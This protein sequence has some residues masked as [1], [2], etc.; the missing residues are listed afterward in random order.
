MLEPLQLVGKANGDIP[1]SCQQGSMW[2]LS[3][4]MQMAEFT[5]CSN[6]LLLPS[7]LIDM[8]AVLLHADCWVYEQVRANVKSRHVH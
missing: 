7:I 2:L 3:C 8:I 4:S 6:I 1:G 5:L